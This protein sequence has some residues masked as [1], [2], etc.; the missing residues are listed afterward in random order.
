MS[1]P[2]YLLCDHCEAKITKDCR[3]FLVTG[4]EMGA[5]GS[6]ETVGYHIDLCAKCWANIIGLINNNRHRDLKTLPCSLALDIKKL[7]N[8]KNV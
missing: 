7:Y 1:N 4:Q 5:A 2:D 8:I 6:T 3:V